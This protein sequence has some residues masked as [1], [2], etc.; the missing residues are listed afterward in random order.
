MIPPVEGSVNNINST[1]G[2][3]GAFHAQESTFCN[4]TS[5]EPP[6]ATVP[7]TEKDTGVIGTPNPSR[8]TPEG[9]AE[10][11]ETSRPENTPG[12]SQTGT[13]RPICP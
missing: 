6:N 10:N 1:G 12:I 5:E 13:Y 4:T 7:P 3:A 9:T 11:N 8:T 2:A